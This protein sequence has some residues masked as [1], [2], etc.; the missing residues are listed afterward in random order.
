MIVGIPKE[1]FPG[2]RRVALTPAVAPSLIKVGHEL[3]IESGAGAEAGFPDEQYQAQGAR[4]AGGRQAL[5]AEADII[6]MVHCPGANPQAGPADLE[7]MRPGQI[8]IGFCEPLAEPDMVRALAQRGVIAF[9]M[10]LV[11]RIT[12][13]QGMDALSSMATIAGYKAVLLAADVLPKMFPML[14]T[15]AGTVKPARLLVIGA[16]VAGLQAIAT[17]RRLGA[18]VEGYDVRPAVKEQVESLGAKFVEL[19][20]E[21]AS[22]E[23]QGGYARALGEDFYR[24]QGE[25]LLRVVGASDVVIT[26]AAVPGKRAPLLISAEMVKAMGPGSVIVDLAAER[27]G[28]CALTQP[29]RTVVEQGV[30]ILGPLNLPSAIPTGASQ[31]YARNVGAFLR[32][33]TRDGR[34]NLAEDDE[35]IRATMIA[36]DGEVV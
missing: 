13:A 6:L 14:M 27:G 35:I 7:L 5:F 24:R 33:L 32:H 16:G 11:P 8:L 21:A 4:L 22:A 19:P 30:T 10:E 20:L 28:N 29:G 9:A 25:L 18:V 1:T 36:R 12:R 26:T 15:A 34:L 3:V 23:D 2:E 17:A 31:M